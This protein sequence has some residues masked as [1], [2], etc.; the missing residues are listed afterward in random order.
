MKKYF[1][2]LLIFQSLIF[3]IEVTIS[4]K[5]DPLITKEETN[6][7]VKYMLKHNIQTDNKDAKNKIK[8]SR[9]LANEYLNKYK[10]SRQ[11]SFEIQFYLEELLKN[12]LIKE[13]LKEIKMNEAVLLSYYKANKHE[14]YKTE[15][16]DFNVY[17]FD[18]F[19]NALS[20]YNQYRNNIEN[21]SP[22][23][24]Q[25]RRTNQNVRQLN[26]ELQLLIKGLVPP[27]LTT[28]QIFANKYTII[29]VTKMHNAEIPQY[30]EVKKD[31]RKRLEQKLLKDTKQKLIDKYLHGLSE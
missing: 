21:I 22:D 25:D 6:Y 9:V 15:E 7:F 29:E 2:S 1:F 8:E 10:L 17:S 4:E 24:I 3:A 13:S 23:A 19:E 20:F 16:I 5:Q 28:P 18:S 12:M 11:T 27:F 30:N 14:F 31:I 26:R